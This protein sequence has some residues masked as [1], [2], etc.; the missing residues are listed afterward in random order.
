V[1]DQFLTQI[2]PNSEITLAHLNDTFS[3]WLRTEYHHRHHSGIEMRPID[4]LQTSIARY[5]LK[6]VD[7]ESLSE[8]FMVSVERTVTNDCTVSFQAIHFE[9]PAAYVGRKV[10]LKYLQERPTEIY[11]Y[12]QGVRI[13]RLHPVDTQANGRTYRPGPRDPHVPFQTLMSQS[14]EVQS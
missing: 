8:F 9:T 4:R 1:R 12:D 14:N 6:R 10:E 7:E 13:Q 11:L 5:P 2:H 3:H